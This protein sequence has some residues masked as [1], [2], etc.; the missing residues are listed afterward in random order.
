MPGGTLIATRR[1]SAPNVRRGARS[2]IVLPRPQG[3]KSS[4]YFDR[5]R[6]G[7]YSTATRQHPRGVKV[8]PETL[9]RNPHYAQYFTRDPK[10]GN[11][12]VRGQQLPGWKAGERAPVA[13]RKSGRRRE[14][15]LWMRRP[16]DGAMY[17]LPETWIVKGRKNDSPVRALRAAGFVFDDDETEALYLETGYPLPEDD[18]EDT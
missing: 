4:V 9:L 12:R 6:G 3:A 15:G 2:T 1:R 5:T 17:F 10:T 18:E 11:M 14:D 7:F 8:D 13:M 16:E